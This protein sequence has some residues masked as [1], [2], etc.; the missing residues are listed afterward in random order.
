[1]FLDDGKIQLIRGDCIEEMQNLGE[2][3]VDMVFADLPYGATGCS[4]DTVIPYELLWPQYE[5][6][7]KKNA[8]LVFTG[9]QPFA[10]MLVASNVKNFLYDWTWNKKIG[11]NFQKVKVRPLRVTEQVMVFSYGKPLYQPQGLVKLDKPKVLSNKGKAGKL[12]HMTSEKVRSHYTQEYTNYPRTLLE[13]NPERGL[14]PTQKP[15]SLVE[16]FIR[17]YTQEN[18]V[19]MDNTMGSGTTAIACINS[20]RRFVGIEMDEDYF[21]VVVQRCEEALA[22]RNTHGL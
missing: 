19:V 3:S 12:A 2:D 5:R 22:K 21:S 17:T 1:M 6:I 8:A 13:F 11:T 20:N 10:S 4:W 18:D 16:Y 14:H 9:T 7:A 15:V